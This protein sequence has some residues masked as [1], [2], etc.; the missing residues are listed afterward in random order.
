MVSVHKCK[1]VWIGASARQ[2][3]SVDG[4]VVEWDCSACRKSFKSEVGLEQHKDRHGQ[5]SCDECGK[6]FSN[7]KSLAQH[8]RSTGHCSDLSWRCPVCKDDWDELMNFVGSC[9]TGPRVR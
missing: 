3:R 8:L 5:I 1:V 9:A 6:L 7:M 2:P 4:H